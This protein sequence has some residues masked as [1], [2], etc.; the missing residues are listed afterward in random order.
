MERAQLQINLDRHG[1]DAAFVSRLPLGEE[2]VDA[3]IA[4]MVAVIDDAS[5]SSMVRTVA[6]NVMGSPPDAM[7]LYEFISR[8]VRFVADPP[9]IEELQHPEELLSQM[10]ETGQARGDCDCLSMLACAMLRA[11]KMNPALIV[12]GPDPSGPFLH[13]LYG[14]IDGDSIVPFDPQER[15]RPGELH[16]LA[17]RVK[18]YQA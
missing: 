7:R 15:V 13:V 5:R 18:V 2:G 8:R 1:S 16:P 11:V 3:T 12:V 9:S 4:G 6:T 14:V 17:K 10:T